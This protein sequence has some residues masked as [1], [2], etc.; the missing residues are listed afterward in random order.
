MSSQPHRFE[1]TCWSVVLAAGH[2]DLG[3]SR[4][5]LCKLCERYWFPVYGFVRRKVNDAH[6]AEDL[7]QAFFRTIIEREQI[8]IV[9]Q[10]RGKFRNFLM[11]AVSNF[12][13]NHFR[14]ADA[15]KRGGD[16]EH[17]PL[18]FEMDFAHGENRFQ[19]IQSDLAPDQ[20]FDRQWA[21]V[22]LQQAMD[23]LCEDYRRSGKEDLFARLKHVI[24]VNPDSQSTY[25]EI[26][27][28][29]KMSE[30]Q[31]K[32]T[33]HRMRSE[34]AAKVREIVAETVTTSEEIEAEIRCFFSLFSK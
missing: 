18:N 23:E 31:I 2:S 10:D 25:R 3:R 9:A 28:D 20:L 22:V 8:K 26:A 19:T 17:F 14:A 34:F 21:L 24:S 4:E 30:A 27:E 13:N 16:V 11:A 1:T 29:L 7:T 12:L 32:V 33:A 15:K 5:A 6:L